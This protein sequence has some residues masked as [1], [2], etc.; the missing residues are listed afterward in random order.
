MGQRINAQGWRTGQHR[1]WAQT[2]VSSN[3][4]DWKDVFFNQFEIE[5]FFQFFLSKVP[6]RRI[7]KLKKLLLV[8]I[9]TFKIQISESTLFIFFYKMRTKRRR[10]KPNYLKKNKQYY[11]RVYRRK[12]LR[13]KF[14]KKMFNKKKINRSLTKPNILKKSIKN[15][16]FIDIKKFT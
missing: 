12:N 14:Y 3:F 13:K 1:S 5:L 16:R 7:I 8:F 6:Y 10:T 11:M 4:A 15:G 2:W 9:K